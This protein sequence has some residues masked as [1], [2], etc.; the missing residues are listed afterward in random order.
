MMMSKT[1]PDI[2]SDIFNLNGLAHKMVFDFD[3][4]ITESNRDIS[5]IPQWNEFDDNSQERFRQR[6]LTNTFGGTLPPQF[7]PRNFAI[8]SG[9]G[10]SITA[11]YHELVN[12]M[13][14]VRLGWRHRLQT[15][16]GPPERLRIKDWMTLDLD[17]SFFPNS[18]RDNFGQSFGLLGARY[19]W[20]VGDR[21]SILSNAYYDL[22]GGAMQLW[23]VGIMNQ[24]STRGSVYAGIRQVKGQ[25][26]QS[27]ILTAS[28]SYAMSDKWISTVGTAYDLAE[29]R[30]RGQSMTMT[31]V[32]ADFLI[33]F[34]TNIDVSKNNFGVGISVEPRFGGNG[35]GGVQST[36]LSNLLGIRQQ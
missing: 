9:T 34:G 27:E 10:S 7:D 23:N 33:H 18:G 4:S 24:R 6:L 28:A 26:F 15:K 29:G 32:G 36:Q 5:L 12:D 16:V 19:A 20:H 3:W 31:R 11:P 21:T 14:V 25:G 17:A 35:S 2:R 1:N 13:H 22:F 30:N 8:R